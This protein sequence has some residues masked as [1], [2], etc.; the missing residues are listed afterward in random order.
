MTFHEA[1]ELK[2][3][4]IVRRE[5]QI[6]NAGLRFASERRRLAEMLALERRQLH[7]SGAPPSRY[8]R[9]SV[10]CLKELRFIIFVE[11]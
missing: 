9:W 8:F 4:A 3:H 5:L 11:R 6:G 1:A 7:K 2:G 10:I